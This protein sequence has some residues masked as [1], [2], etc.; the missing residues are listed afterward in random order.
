MKKHTKKRYGK[1]N[2]KGMTLVEMITTFALIGIFMVAA[3]RM[4]SYVIGIYYAASGNSY[5]LQV[6]GIISGKVIGQIEGACNAQT[7]VVSISENGISQI[8]FADATG[9][10]VTITAQPLKD[11]NEEQNY[12]TI[13]YDPVTEGSIKY[14]AVDWR[15]DPGVYMGYYVKNLEFENPGPDYPENVMR[16]I[17]TLHHERYGDY[18]S[19]Y[20]IKCANVEEIQ[21]K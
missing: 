15:F 19:T 7:P 9:S 11:G 20:Y 6:S 18:I 8:H 5:G 12:L 2:N 3:T 10:Y 17:L 21:F 16:M 13:H 1:L 14:E 4:I